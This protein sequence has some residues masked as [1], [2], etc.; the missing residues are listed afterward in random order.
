MADATAEMPI[1]AAPAPED[2][3]RVSHGFVQV[4]VHAG[5][6]ETVRPIEVAPG[7]EPEVAFRVIA[8][9][10][11][12]RDMVGAAVTLRVTEIVCVPAVPAF[13]V[14]APVCVPAARL[15][16]EAE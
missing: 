14:T 6:P 10:A 3:E 12:T 5:A 9:G 13:T 15:L 8:F 4:A 11:A 1:V 7:F 2:C 16:V